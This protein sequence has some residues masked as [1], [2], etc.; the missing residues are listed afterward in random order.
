[1]EWIAALESGP[2][3]LYTGAIGWLA[4]GEGGCPDLALSVAIRTVTL[5]R[6][7]RGRGGEPT[8]LRPL[9]LGVG[10]GI[11]H[12]SVADDEY[13]ET[14]WK[15]R[16]LTALDPGIELFE[17]MRATRGGGVPLLARHRRRLAESARTLGFAFDRPAF[18]ELL[19][20]TL[21][22]LAPTAGAD[23]PLRVRMG[24][25][26]DGALA[27]NHGPLAAL[28]GGQGTPADPVRVLLAQ[29][30]LAP[31]RPLAVHKTTERERYDQGVRDAEAQGGF[32]TL[33]FG[34][35]G[36]LL[37]GGRSNVFL[38]LAGRWFTP[39]LA[40]GVLPGVLRGMLLEDPA[41]RASERRLYRDDLERAEAVVVC[42][43]LRGVLHA[44]ATEG[45]GATFL[46]TGGAEPHA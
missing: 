2:R 23:E 36:E 46:S 37:E 34:E 28:R 26:F 30:A 19:E 41:W 29:Q 6:E 42:N 4:R 7:T 25:R 8:G 22:S 16:F 15:A 17:T 44:T 13:Q 21:R 32:D 14:H 9:T 40:D 20:R 5:A 10:G 38:R 24:L 35:Q 11:V 33:F 43:A 39:P 27:V 31:D 45:C 1:M 12:D 18:D 3:G